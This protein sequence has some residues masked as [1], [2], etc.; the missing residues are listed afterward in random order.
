MLTSLPHGS[1]ACGSGR[2][3]KLKQAAS[4]KIRF[5]PSVCQSHSASMIVATSHPLALCNRTQE[6]LC[7]A[8]EHVLQLSGFNHVL[9]VSCIFVL[10]EQPEV[11][12]APKLSTGVPLCVTP[13]HRQS[14]EVEQVGFYSFKVLFCSLSAAMATI[15]QKPDK[16]VLLRQRALEK[17][18]LSASFRKVESVN[19]SQSI[20]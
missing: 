6:A 15:S 11:A 16:Q 5:S 10:H 1:A 20:P 19:I 18:R 7:H 13:Q 14:S 12:S 17:F 9:D 2:Q 8:C 3:T 4:Q